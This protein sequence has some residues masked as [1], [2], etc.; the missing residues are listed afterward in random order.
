M[1]EQ[2]QIAALY[3]KCEA[4]RSSYLTRGR[5]SSRL[6]VPTILPEDGNQSA[7]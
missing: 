4:Q 5:D 2:G 3:G 1:N 7:T 6:T